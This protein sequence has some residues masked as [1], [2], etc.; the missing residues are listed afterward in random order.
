MPKFAAGYNPQQ[1]P[2]IFTVYPIKPIFIL[3]TAAFSDIKGDISEGR[4][5]TIVLYTFLI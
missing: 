5:P 1:L 4:F 3:F 2:S